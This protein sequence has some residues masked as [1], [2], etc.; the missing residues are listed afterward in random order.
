MSDHPH[1]A[2]GSLAPEFT[3]V[4]STGTDISLAQ[5]RSKTNVYL[6]FVREFI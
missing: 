1:L 6:F 2:V 5:V 4:A 3:L